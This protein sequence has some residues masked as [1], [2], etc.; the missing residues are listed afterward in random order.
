[1][2]IRA[3][4]TDGIAALL[5]REDMFVEIGVIVQAVQIMNIAE[6]DSL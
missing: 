3:A 1:M 4:A 2:L 6:M 5:T